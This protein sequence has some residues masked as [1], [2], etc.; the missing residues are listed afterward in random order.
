MRSFNLLVLFI[1]FSVFISCRE[2]K[3]VFPEEP[4]DAAIFVSSNPRGASIFHSNEFTNKITPAW[5]QHL[6]Q[7]Y[8]R[9]TLKYEGYVDTSVILLLNPSQKKYLSIQMRTMNN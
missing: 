6:D 7:G 9:I 3:I 2:D 1:L 8:H 4:V 5:V